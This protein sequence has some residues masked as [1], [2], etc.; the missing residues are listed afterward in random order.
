MDRIDG[1][2]VWLV[3]VRLALAFALFTLVSLTLLALITFTLVFLP[4]VSF[5]FFLLSWGQLHRPLPL[6][7]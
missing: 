3:L 6:A 5:V 4:L 2:N 7:S 1:R